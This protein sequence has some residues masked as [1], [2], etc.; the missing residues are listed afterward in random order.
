METMFQLIYLKSTAPRKDKE[1]FKSY[2]SREKQQMENIKQNPMYLFMDT[3]Y[4]VL[5]QGNVRAHQFD[6]PATFDKINMDNALK[7]YKERIGNAKGMYYTFVGSFKIDE[8]KP[9]IEKYLGGLP[10]DEIEMK[11]KDIGLFPVQG[12]KEFT[13]KKG[14][15]QQAMLTH[16][17]NGKSVFTPDD[18]FYLAQLNEV[19]NNYIIDTIREKM[20]AIYGGGTGG[21]I[22]KYPRQ[23][24]MIQ[25]YFPCS[26]DNIDKVNEAYLK[27]IDKVKID[28][29]ISDSDWERVKEPALK[30]YQVDIKTNR[31]WLNGLINAN[32]YLTDPNRIMSFEQRI[33]GTTPA[34]LSQIA[35]KFYTNKNIF[36]AKWVPETTD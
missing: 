18:N 10:S 19:I 5:Y 20:S 28:G 14:K 4:N 6:S 29:G 16:Y 35:R 3:T 26:P 34:K 13:L 30:K 25:T 17:I 2:I 24:Y 1:A 23:E 7:F 11:A 8:I 27:I 22:E 9:L 32:Y 36:T 31:Y 15:E 21:S 33:N 12:K